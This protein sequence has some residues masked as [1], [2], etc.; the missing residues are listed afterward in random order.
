MTQD[1][2]N[3]GGVLRLVEYIYRR[4]EAAGLEP[5]ILHY[6]R[7]E[8]HPELHAS[9]ANLL[10]GELNLRPASKEYIFNG[11]RAQAIGAMFP[12]WEPNRLHANRLWRKSLSQFDKFILITG[13]A[14]TG[15]PLAELQ[16]KFVAWV[17]ST[18]ETDR[19]ERL[20]QSRGISNWIEKVGLKSVLSY[21]KKVLQAASRV[22]AVSE[23]AKK[24][25]AQIYGKEISVWPYPIDTQKF[26]RAGAAVGAHHADNNHADMPHRFLFVGRANDPRKRI[27]LFFQACNELHRKSPNLDFVA[28]VVSSE[29][30]LIDN[31]NFKIEHLNFV[32]EEELI[33]LYQ[34]ST[35]FVLTSEQEGLGIAAME[36]M[37]C[38][39]PVISTRCGGPETFIADKITGF[40]VDDEPEVIANRMLQLA[41]DDGLQNRLGIASREKI[42]GEFS[43]KV[44]NERFEDMLRNSN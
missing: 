20:S 10:N 43:Q 12:E 32:S 21:E 4:A 30:P 31:L 18:V 35:A 23:D 42:D 8:K 11:M 7:F 6:A 37:S 40:F 1:P 34:N 16:K 26:S 3:Y 36:A 22:M 15:L 25:L 27:E 9:L 38:G 5:T 17:S 24:H 44:W 14:Q 29:I 28:T 39:L 13:S 33:N 41:I 2:A 19:R